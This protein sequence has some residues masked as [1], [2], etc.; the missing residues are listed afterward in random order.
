MWVDDADDDP[1]FHVRRLRC[2]EPRDEQAELDLAARIVTDPLPRSRPLWAAVIVTGLAA[3]R[4][5]VIIVLHHVVADGIAGLG[6]LRRL[7]DGVS[8]P[9]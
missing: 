1:A 8:Q 3:R 9:P 5:A 2:A 4:V 6:I 7:A